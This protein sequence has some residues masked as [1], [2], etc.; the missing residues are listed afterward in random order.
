MESVIIH[1]AELQGE[2]Q[3]AVKNWMR[4]QRPQLIAFP[5]KGLHMRGYNFY[6]NNIS[7][8]IIKEIVS[9]KS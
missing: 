8:F 5:Y 2:L 1:K 6:W 7:Y 9:K 4:K 3:L